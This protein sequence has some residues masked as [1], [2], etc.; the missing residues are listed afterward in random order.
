MWMR[1]P[2]HSDGNSIAF[3]LTR[4]HAGNI[5]EQPLADGAPVQLTKFTNEDMF[6]FAWSGDGKKL[7]FFRGQRKTDVVMMSNLN[8]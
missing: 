6:S 5:W 8:H 7:A 2:V 1:A 3:L 4:D